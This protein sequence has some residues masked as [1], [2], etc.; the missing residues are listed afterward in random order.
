MR[1]IVLALIGAML[2]ACATAEPPPVKVN[3]RLYVANES[4]NSL[5]VI[6]AGALALSKDAGPA[7]LPDAAAMGAVRDHPDLVVASLSQEHGVIRADDAA[8]LAGRFPVGSPIEIVPNHSCL[9]VAHFDEYVVMRGGDVVD[10][11]PVA[12]G[13]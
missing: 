7:H 10:R 13:R 12:R 3:N 5:S 11:W 6:D 4:G 8:V 1:T 9:T 2:A